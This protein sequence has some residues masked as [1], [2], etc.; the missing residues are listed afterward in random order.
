[1]TNL[2]PNHKQYNEDKK[3]DQAQ[4]FKLNN[5]LKSF[6]KIFVE[7]QIEYC[8]ISRNFEYSTP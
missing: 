2:T 7:M 1:M 8:Y 6:Y 3:L 4:Y 5:Y